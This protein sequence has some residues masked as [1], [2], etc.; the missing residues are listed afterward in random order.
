MKS[1]TEREEKDIYYCLKHCL[2]RMGIRE[3]SWGWIFCANYCMFQ[4]PFDRISKVE[5][6][7]G[8]VRNKQTRRKSDKWL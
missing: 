8:T 4:S 1:G 2:W 5:A 3:R 7:N 6:Y